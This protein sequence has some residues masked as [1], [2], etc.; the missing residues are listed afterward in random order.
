MPAA[1]VGKCGGPPRGVGHI[2][3]QRSPPSETCVIPPRL[4][5]AIQPVWRIFRK[6][7]SQASWPDRDQS[8]ELDGV[9]PSELL[10]DPLVGRVR[11][12]PHRSAR[13]LPH[14]SARRFRLPVA[15]GE[16]SDLIPT[17]VVIQGVVLDE[18]VV[19]GAVLYPMACATPVDKVG[20][21]SGR[22]SDYGVERLSDLA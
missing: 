10:T 14:R 15:L 8:L 6:L 1:Q 18:T 3:I 17:E 13:R 21:S 11:A 20:G 22:L 2:S 9:R 5:Q 16:R 19:G 12:A 4:G 7:L